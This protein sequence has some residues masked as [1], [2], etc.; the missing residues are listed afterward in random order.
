MCTL[1]GK[2]DF[3]DVVEV[4]ILRQG[5]EPG[6]SSWPNGITRVLIREREAG[7][8]EREVITEAEARAM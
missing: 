2:R 7:Q 3:A 5:E 1:L 4:R 6:L 8:S